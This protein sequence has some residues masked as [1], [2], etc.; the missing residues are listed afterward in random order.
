MN[1]SEEKRRLIYMIK[2]IEQLLERDYSD[3][4]YKDKNV[5][6]HLKVLTHS[7]DNGMTAIYTELSSK[8]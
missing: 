8:R 6:A 4:E 3:V 2:S 1:K 7:A 5:N